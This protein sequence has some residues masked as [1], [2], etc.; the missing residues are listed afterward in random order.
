[1]VTFRQS[2]GQEIKLKGVRTYT[3]KDYTAGSPM[4]ADISRITDGKCETNYGLRVNISNEHILK[5]IGFNMFNQNLY[6]TTGCCECESGCA[7]YDGNLITNLFIA[8]AAKNP[9]NYYTVQGYATVAL[10]TAT[11][12]ISVN[13]ALGVS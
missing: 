13:Y 8:E 2:A 9:N 10:T 6:I 1:M 11:H 4:V 7:T 5:Q 12:G 3:R